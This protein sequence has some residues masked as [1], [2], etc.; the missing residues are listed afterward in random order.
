MMITEGIAADNA[1]LLV[2]V[3]ERVRQTTHNRIRN[4]TVE[5]IEGRFVVGGQVA[6]QHMKQLALQGALE[7]L[8]GEQFA[9]R[10]TV[11]PIPPVRDMD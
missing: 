4:L 1:S 2:L 7:L 8:S 11:L 5:E 3:A 6:S 9:A 10:I